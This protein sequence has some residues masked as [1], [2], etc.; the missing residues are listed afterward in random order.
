MASFV[1]LGAA[2]LDAAH[3]AQ[4]ILTSGTT[5]SVPIDWNNS[6]NA[7]EVIGGG[8]GG[9][10]GSSSSVD[11]GAGGGGG[12]AYSKIT[13]LSLQPGAVVTYQIG[14]GGSWG[15]VGS[16]GSAGGDSY[17]NGSGAS[18]ASQ[19]VCA[20]GGGGGSISSG[21][22][23]ASGGAGGAAASGIGAVRYSGGAGGGSGATSN[24]GGGGGGAAGPNGNGGAGGTSGQN[25]SGAGGGGNGGGS[26][27]ASA[28]AGGNNYAGTGGGSAGSTGVP[29]G[30][31]SNGGGG[32]AGYWNGSAWVNNA[33]GSG[34]TG[35]EWDSTHGSGGGAASGAGGGGTTV[36]ANGSAGLYGGGGAGRSGLGTAGS[37]GA[38][39]LIVITYTPLP[40]PPPPPP[41]SALQIFLTSGTT[42]TVP[43][44]WNN[45]NNAIEVIGGGGGGGGGSSSSVDEG[46][47]GGGGGAYSKTANLSLQAG[48]TIT[49]QVGTGGSAGN[50]GSAGSAGG[51]SYFN[52]SGAS[53]ASQSVCAKGGGGGSISSG[54]NA[55]S[56]GAGGAAA[57]GIGAVRYSGGAGGGSGATSNG[58]GGGGGAAGPNGNG[59]AGGTSGQNGSGAGGGGNGGG[60]NGASAGA[61]GNNYAGTGGGSAGSTGVPGGN[62]SNGGGGGAGYWNGSAWVNNAGGSGSTGTEWDSTH[63]SGGGAASGAGGGGTTVGANG[64][65]GLYGGGGAG[66]SGLGTAGSAGAQGLIVITYTP[67][68]TTPP[69]GGGGGTSTSGTR[70]SS[71]AYDPTSGLMTQEVI[72][73]GTAALRL[74]TD[75]TYDGFGN[76]L[77]SAASGADIATRSASG[78]YDAQGRFATGVTNA[79]GQSESWQFDPRFGKPTSHTGPNGLTTSW[80]YDSFGRKILEVRP[81]GTQTKWS[82]QFCNGVNGGTAACVSGAIYLVQATPLAA[83][84]ATQNGANSIIYLDSLERPIASDSQGFDGS[85][86]RTS[87]QYDSLGR[88]KQQSRPYF[89][90]GGTAQWATFTYDVLGRV[91]TETAPDTSV[92]QHAYHGL[93]STVTNALSQTRTVKRDSQGHVIS[94]TDA[95]NNTISYVYGPF[96]ELVQTVDAAG[97]AVT[98]TYDTRGRKIASSDPDMGAWSYSYNT[99]NELTSQT[100][101]KSQTTTLSYDKIGRLIQRVE[102]DMTSVWTYDTAVHGIGQLASAS[103]TSGQGAG[104]QRAYT[105][106]A[107][108]RPAQVALTIAGTVYTMAGTYDANGRL[109]TVTYP[110]GFT[111][112]Y[113]R[114][115]LGDVSGLNGAGG[116]SFWTANTVDA[117]MRI[118]QQTAGNGVVTQQG[119]DAATGRLLSIQ[120]GSG[121]SIANFAYTYDAIGNLLTRTDGNTG[122]SETLVYDSL[123]RLTQSTVALSPTPLVKS[124]NYDSIGNLTAKSDVGT[125]TYPAAGSTRPHAVTSVSGG[126]ITT[127]FSYDANGNQTAGLGRTIAYSAANMPTTVSQ[128]AR[129]IGLGYD[130]DHQRFMQTAPEGTTLY[131]SAFGVRA[132]LLAGNQWTEYLIVGGA[133]VGARFSNATS[134]AVTLRYFHADHLGSVSVLTNEQGA[135]AERDSYDAWGKRRAAN[136]ADDP[137]GSVTSQTT[138]GFTGQEHLAN[139]GLINF[140]ARLYDPIVGRFTSPD[141]IVPD[142]SD[143]QS[144]NRYT[145]VRNRPLSVTDPS[146]HDDTTLP[147]IEVI[148]SNFDSSSWNFS[149]P[150]N[151]YLTG[152]NSSGAWYSYQLN[153]SF[154]SIGNQIQYLIWKRALEA[155]GFQVVGGV[156]SPQGQVFGGTRIGSQQAAVPPAPAQTV[157]AGFA[158]GSAGYSYV[159]GPGFDTLA[160]NPGL[161]H[162]LQCMGMCHGYSVDPSATIAT[163]SNSPGLFISAAAIGLLIPGPGELEGAA[164]VGGKIVTGPWSRGVTNVVEDGVFT[165]CAAGSCVSAT[166]Q[167]LTNGA[168][169]EEQLLSKLGEWSNPVALARELNRLDPSAAWKAGYFV[170]GADALAV[171]KSGRVGLVLQAPGTAAHMVTVEP[172]ATAGRFLVRDTGAGVTYEVGSEWIKTFV[173]GG[174]WR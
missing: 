166:G 53:C 12:G 116:Q 107:L 119:F 5:W 127:S 44:D 19:S 171:A 79:L 113:P 54:Y 96:G 11:E 65:A 57:S 40:P 100:D 62:G 84:G 140:N 61:G 20:K 122:L 114:T 55:A 163:P 64:S 69:G 173:A 10:G 102:P 39:G 82:Y 148:G 14:S 89:A 174:V 43:S 142:P 128:G 109:N 21:Y 25:G 52:G 71:F 95:L 150:N 133:M 35:T 73:P 126:A 158:M 36:G 111:V 91:L 68:S 8:G 86:V 167:V 130:P 141:S 151:P 98:A 112:S 76:K 101:A 125:Y 50:V 59:G 66:R 22:N 7:I 168:V 74:Q 15:N 129:T 90:S 9:G 132:E 139:V 3:A 88:V 153:V 161:L 32:G 33:G 99:A 144:L 2:P 38:Q 37:A 41:G 23:A 16:A 120:A 1:L 108:T 118:T 45:S 78:S 72:E 159:Q 42:W 97:N 28:G 146:G 63:G 103:I 170:D 160:L 58:G 135:T 47:G 136:G 60:S 117:E 110:S 149:I 123:N 121:S 131:F 13:N 147:T 51:D 169:S 26:N 115:S 93:V 92:T 143:L 34:S 138:R 4:I 70:S 77:T 18:C 145:Y 80:S 17:F 162:S 172:L 81:D 106:D 6:A 31:G 157:A 164:L 156:V 85:M 105:Y 56:G 137:T 87:K 67:V 124:Y 27:G 30:N 83:D 94:I 165:Q 29:G 46:A 155:K 152:I 104:Y 134:G 49:Y 24:G 48:A 154:N 75:Y